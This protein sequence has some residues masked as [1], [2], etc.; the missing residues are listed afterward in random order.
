MRFFK[1]YNL[2]PALVLGAVT[3][4]AALG[5]ASADLGVDFDA[6]QTSTAT[7]LGGYIGWAIAIGVAVIAAFALLGYFKSGSAGRSK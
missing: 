5:Q 4:T 6:L 2:L 1:F 7:Q 3:S